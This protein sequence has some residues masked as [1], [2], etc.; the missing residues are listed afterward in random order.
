MLKEVDSAA[1]SAAPM[2]TRINTVQEDRAG[3]VATLEL[4][5]TTPLARVPMISK[6]DSCL[7]RMHFKVFG[8][9]SLQ[10]PTLKSVD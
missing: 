2:W 3:T 6:I 4:S 5:F 8:N 7:G 1:A 10:R 9:A